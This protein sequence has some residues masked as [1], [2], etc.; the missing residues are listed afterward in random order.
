MI[1]VPNDGFLT[2]LESNDK[3]KNLL[4]EVKPTGIEVIVHF[5]PENVLNTEKYQQLVQRVGAKRQ[6]IANDR[7]K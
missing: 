3:L 4:N 6:L 7:N 5:T 1:D 2:T